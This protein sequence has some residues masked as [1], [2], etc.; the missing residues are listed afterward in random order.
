[1]FCGLGE[2]STIDSQYNGNMLRLHK[3]ENKEFFND[4]SKFKDLDVV[5][6]SAAVTSGLDV[7]GCGFDYVIGCIKTGQFSP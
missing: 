7:T 6:H 3:T 2:S 4:I 1:M 5:I